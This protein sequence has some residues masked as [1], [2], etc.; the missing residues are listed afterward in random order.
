[1]RCFARDTGTCI[2]GIR[3]M[4]WWS[5]AV[6][7]CRFW[8]FDFCGQSMTPRALILPCPQWLLGIE[9]GGRFDLF[10]RRPQPIISPTCVDHLPW[11]ARSGPPGTRS[12]LLPLE[13][14]PCVGGTPRI[15]TDDVPFAVLPSL[16]LL[17]APDSLSITP[18]SWLFAAIGE[19][20]ELG[21]LGSEI[22]LGMA[23]LVLRVA[24]LPFPWV[25]L[26][27]RTSRPRRSVDGWGLPM[28]ESGMARWVWRGPRSRC[29]PIWTGL[30]TSTKNNSNGWGD[31]TAPRGTKE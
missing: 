9:M 12:T 6:S 21:T 22:F 3:G 30:D 5:S 16:Q 18:S 28:Q 26:A 29:G 27:S 7:V 31:W 20:R 1:M 23:M 2:V 8:A 24:F 17:A 4:Q 15:P 25:D 19:P 11:L 10:F 14:A 13:D